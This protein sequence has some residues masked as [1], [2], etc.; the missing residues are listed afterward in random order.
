MRE[1]LIGK[2]RNGIMIK[3]FTNFNKTTT[4]T[5]DSIKND[6]DTFDKLIEGINY[7]KIKS[8]DNRVIKLHSD[9][10]KQNNPVKKQI[11]TK[12]IAILKLQIEIENL[13]GK[14]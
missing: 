3:R 2:K 7:E 9:L 11:I 1:V 10:S 6:G 14:N 8:Y 12:E 5:Y 13:K 4:I